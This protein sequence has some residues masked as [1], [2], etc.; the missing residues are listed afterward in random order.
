V[1]AVHRIEY[2][3]ALL[4]P[5]QLITNLFTIGSLTVYLPGYFCISFAQQLPNLSIAVE[6]DDFSKVKISNR[7]IPEGFLK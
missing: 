5:K 1:D 3:V 7:K 2:C 4:F 6:E